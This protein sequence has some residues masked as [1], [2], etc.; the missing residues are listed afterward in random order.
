M[1]Y[2]Y[3]NICN[4]NFI[5]H[6]SA[7]LVKLIMQMMKSTKTLGD[8]M[9]GAGEGCQPLVHLIRP[10]DWCRNSILLLEYIDV[11]CNLSC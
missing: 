7:V 10:G 4:G 9:P 8:I 6:F 3:L 1:I 11:C 2:Y 5:F